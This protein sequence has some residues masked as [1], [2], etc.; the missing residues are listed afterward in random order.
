MS[1]MNRPWNL[2]PDPDGK[3]RELAVVLQGASH[4]VK[5]EEGSRVE[6]FDNDNFIC[7][8]EKEQ[9]VLL[10][11]AVEYFTKLLKANEK[12]QFALVSRGWAYYL[13]GKPDKA[14]ADFDSFLKR[15]R[16]GTDGGL[17]EPGRW[18]GLVNRGLVF[19]EQG[20][21]KKALADLDEAV[22]IAPG[23]SV[24]QT[25]RGYT[26]ELMG[27]YEKAIADYR[28]T[29]HF[30]GMNNLAWLRATC[31]DA[32]F[33]DATEAVELAQ[34][35]CGTTRN[36]E[37]MFLDTLAAAYA[38]AGKF[39]EAVKT[40]EKALE[41]KSFVILYGEEAQ[42]RLQLYKD[43]KPFRAGGEEVSGGRPVYCPS[44]LASSLI[45]RSADL[46]LSLSA[47][48]PSVGIDLRAPSRSPR[49]RSLS[50]FNRS[51]SGD[52][53]SVISFFAASKFGTRP[54]RTTSL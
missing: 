47:T 30:L 54:S 51:A 37:G 46:T 40:Q 28:A 10:P 42:K 26:Y 9:L 53:G 32:K 49:A 44:L 43:K 23:R 15:A 5:G 29:G 16:A 8:I 38:E 45:V 36:R 17:T 3:P 24:A 13:L 1:V 12:D 35:A 48:L 25:N 20:E 4:G 39:A 19:A 33:R 18:E 50:C 34:R 52:F 2:P 7:W 11:D 14:I 6:V 27:D 21:F 41:D 31:S 22:K